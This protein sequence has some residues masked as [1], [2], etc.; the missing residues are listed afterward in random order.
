MTETEGVRPKKWTLA[1][2]QKKRSQNNH[3]FLATRQQK[4]Y[5]L[6]NFVAIAQAPPPEYSASAG[7]DSVRFT[8][9]LCPIEI[10]RDLDRL[11]PYEIRC[12]IIVD[13]IMILCQTN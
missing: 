6:F 7:T 8:T 5:G 12:S 10:L 13:D 2:G 1:T 3:Y 11:G 9:D 4:P